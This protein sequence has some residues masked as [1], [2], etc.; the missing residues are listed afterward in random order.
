[1]NT[2]FQKT[3][4]ILIRNFADYYKRSSFR[5]L[6]AVGL[7]EYPLPKIVNN[8]GFGDQRPKQPHIVG[9]NDDTGEI[10]IGILK[11][12]SDNLE[13][14]SALTEYD[15][16]LNLTHDDDNVRLCVYLPTDRVQEFNSLIT[17]YLHPDF[18]NKIIV[19]TYSDID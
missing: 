15:L 5:I 16:Y 3:F 19:A 7:E 4:D 18:Y 11:T 17:R 1:M 14:A 10:I 8:D 13:S 2:D 6:N 12:I 9:V